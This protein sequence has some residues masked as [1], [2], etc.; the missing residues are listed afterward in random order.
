M[1]I[2]ILGP[3]CAKCKKAEK[4]VREAVEESGRDVQVEKVSDIQ[5][6][7]SH[8]VF[9]TPAVVVDGEVKVTGAVP[10]KKDVLSWLA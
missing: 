3:G 1:I 8:G 10:G 7:V 5:E 4:V 9:T 6:I 2:K